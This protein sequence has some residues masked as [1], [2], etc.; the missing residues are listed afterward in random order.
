MQFEGEKGLGEWRGKGLGFCCCYG[1]LFSVFK[2]HGS[3]E[4]D[5]VTKELSVSNLDEK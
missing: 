5:R 2:P 4:D 1:V 3:Q